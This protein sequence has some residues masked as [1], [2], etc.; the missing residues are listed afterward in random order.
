MAEV[1]GTSGKDFY[2]VK[3]GENYEALEGDDEITYEKGGTAQGGA[4]NDKMTVPDGFSKYDATVWYWSSPK[5]IYVDLE[6]GYALDGY[7]TR[8]T[9]INVHNV[10]ASNKTV[11]GGMVHLVMMHFGLV[12]GLGTIKAAKRV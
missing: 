1:K 9:L 11:I 12:L 6:A 2:T 10:T 3:N 5:A 7:G 8:D 4:G